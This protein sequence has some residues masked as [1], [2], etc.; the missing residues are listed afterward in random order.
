MNHK[1]GRPTL[2][3]RTPNGFKKSLNEGNIFR[4]ATAIQKLAF[5]SLDAAPVQVANTPLIVM[6]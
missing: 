5:N 2:I 1:T 6:L 4:M 3:Y